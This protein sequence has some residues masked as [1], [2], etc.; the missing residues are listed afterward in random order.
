MNSEHEQL[1]ALT[2]ILKQ[3]LIFMMI[4]NWNGK[5]F[6]NVKELAVMA[7]DI[8]KVISELGQQNEQQESNCKVIKLHPEKE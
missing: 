3:K 5:D 4:K 8:I 2:A 7:D 1:K 6:T